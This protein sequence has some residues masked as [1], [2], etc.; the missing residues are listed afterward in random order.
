MNQA[1]YEWDAHRPILESA[2]ALSASAIAA[3]KQREHTAGVEELDDKHRAVL[4]Y[5]DAMTLGC[6]VPDKVFASLREALGEERMVV[7]LTATVAAYN[8]VSRFLVALDVGEMRG[9]YGVDMS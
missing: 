6:T 4:E 3:L 8:C 7:E 2:K 1:W 5:T 9:K